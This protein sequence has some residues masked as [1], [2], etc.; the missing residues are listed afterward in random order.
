MNETLIYTVHEVAKILHSSPN[1]VYKLIE[2]GYLPAI[3]LGSIKV[4]KSS[5]EQF[6]IENQGN[7]LSNLNLIKKLEIIGQ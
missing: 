3:K 5:L 1:Y 4:L 6:L 2:Y 7:D